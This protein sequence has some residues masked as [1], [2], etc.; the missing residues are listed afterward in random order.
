MKLCYS[1]PVPFCYLMNMAW[2]FDDC[3]TYRCVYDY[4]T[5]HL[6]VEH[7]GSGL[8]DGIMDS[9]PSD[10]CS[11]PIGEKGNGSQVRT[12]GLTRV[13]KDPSDL[14]RVQTS[15]QKLLS[16]LNLSPI[17]CECVSIGRKGKI[18]RFWRNI[19]QQT[20]FS[21][22][23][24]YEARLISQRASLFELITKSI[25]MASFEKARSSY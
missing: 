9:S 2:F 14:K 1:H 6:L 18:R 24:K 17:F 16:Q 23:R 7:D 4:L 13:E 20:F 15:G 5:W 10:P 3:E 22:R 21:R 8:V 12:L 11:S 19:S 25:L